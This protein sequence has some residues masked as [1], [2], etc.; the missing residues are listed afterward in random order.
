MS[1]ENMIEIHDLD[2]AYE[3]GATVL[4]KVDL[5]IKEGES[6]GIIGPNGGGK[7]TLLKLILGLIQPSSGS[8]RVLG[9]P[10]VEARRWVGY[11]PQYHQLDSAFPV[12][13]EE[14]VLQ[15]TLHRNAWGRYPA[16]ARKAAADALEE[17][18]IAN[19]AKRS[20]AELS[21]GQRQRVLIARALAGHP[22][23]LLLDEP[24]ANVDPGAEEQFYATLKCLRRSMS[25]LTVSHDLGFVSR[26]IDRV[27]CVNKHVVVHEGG[28]LDQA[29]ADRIYRHGVHLVEHQHGCFC[30]CG[31]REV[32]E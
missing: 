21:G 23:L 27:I 10:P 9:L 1:M 13:A 8:I 19:L 25:I 7:S 22:K 2:F 4:E 11:M 3:G 20:F 18:G 32:H 6:A 17:M 5:T 31:G 14:V 29:T 26:E 24:P 12:L 30:N 28:T 15:G 16:A